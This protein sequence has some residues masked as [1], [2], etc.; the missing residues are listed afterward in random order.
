MGAS[1]TPRK[2]DTL[3]EAAV[4]LAD[5]ALAAFVAQYADPSRDHGLVAV[6]FSGGADSTALLLAAARRWPGRV[7]ALHVHHGLQAA[8]DDFWRHCENLCSFWGIPFV[9]RR[10][11]ARHA[12][13]QS[14]EDAAR[15][16][17]YAALAAMAQDAHASCVLLAQHADD[18]VETLILALSRGAGLPGLAAMP[19]IFIRHGMCFARP[20]L[21]TPGQALR[22]WLAAS[23][24]DWVDDPT[25]R[26]RSFTRNRI[27]LDVLPV[28]EQVFPKFRDTFARSARHAA[29]AQVVLDEVAEEDLQ[30]TGVPPVI[31]ALQKFSQ[32]RQANLLRHWL[33]RDYGI[34]PSSAQLAELQRQ[35][36]R[37]RTRGHH[38]RLKVGAGIVARQG[39]CLVYTRF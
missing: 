27:R 28:I 25:N 3:P 32:A 7:V 18:Q 33:R 4:G 14:P 15:Q 8:A 35:L 10:V 26:D 23:H 21:Q 24:V 39:A 2:T 1:T 16:S 37:C 5:L 36:A 6:A 30:V 12:P 19:P 17:R 9:G 38:L 29:E 31:G 11:D 34:A 13:R 20:L 22:T